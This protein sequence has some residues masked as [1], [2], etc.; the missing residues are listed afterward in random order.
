MKVR[1]SASDVS[2]TRMAYRAPT[3][4]LRRPRAHEQRSFFH[5]ANVARPSSSIIF[6][7]LQLS[8]PTTTWRQYR[9]LLPA[10]QTADPCPDNANCADE[11]EDIQKP[12]GAVPPEGRYKLTQFFLARP[13]TPLTSASAVFQAADLHLD[14]GCGSGCII[15]WSSRQPRVHKHF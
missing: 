1:Q 6:R 4:I 5:F 14:L 9:S 12:H 7:P 15:R 3:E 2:D 10:H 8:T 13:Q 11:K